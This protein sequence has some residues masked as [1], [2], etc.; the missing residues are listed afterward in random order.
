MTSLELW[1]GMRELEEKEILRIQRREQKEREKF[2]QEL[3]E[4]EEQLRK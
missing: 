3:R 2:E 1:L 4:E